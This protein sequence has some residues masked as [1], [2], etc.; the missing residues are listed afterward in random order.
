MARV[1]WL[2]QKPPRIEP[3]LGVHSLGCRGYSGFKQVPPLIHKLPRLTTGRSRTK[4]PEM[5]KV[6]KEAQ[7]RKL[8]LDLSP[9]QQGQKKKGEQEQH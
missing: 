1:P 7:L 9:E 6:K 2:G 4:F 8:P 5:L 3:A